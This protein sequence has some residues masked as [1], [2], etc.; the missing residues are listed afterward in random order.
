[1][2]GLRVR[3]WVLDVHV[4]RA[5]SRCTTQ[6]TSSGALRLG[7]GQI[8]PVDAEVEAVTLNGSA[9]EYV[10]ESAMRGLMVRG[11]AEITAGQT[12]VLEIVVK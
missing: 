10:L 12:V 1:V 2:T 3:D 7:I 5:G 11:E 9:L 4:A 6:V 8:L